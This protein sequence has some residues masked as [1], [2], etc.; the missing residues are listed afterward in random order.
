MLEKHFVRLWADAGCFYFL[1]RIVRKYGTDGKWP[2]IWMS[3][4]RTIHYNGKKHTPELFLKI[5][6]LERLAAPSD[7]YSE[8]EAYAL[9]NTWDHVEVRGGNFTENS[10]KIQKVLKHQYF[11]YMLYIYNIIKY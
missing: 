8:I 1:E 10:K 6:E 3:I 7:L 11:L 9:T 5:K 2:S 4:K